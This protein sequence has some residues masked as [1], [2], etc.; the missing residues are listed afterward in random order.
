MGNWGEKTQLI[1]VITPL[2]TSRW[3]PWRYYTSTWLNKWSKSTSSSPYDNGFPSCLFVF[4][5][6][7]NMGS[8][9]GVPGKGHGAS[10]I[11]TG[12]GLEKNG[13]SGAARIQ[14]NDGMN[15]WPKS[16]ENKN[17]W[18]GSKGYNLLIHAISLGV[19]PTDPRPRFE[20]PWFLQWATTRVTTPLRG[21]FF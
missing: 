11:V 18:L 6:A 21:I 7:S 13:L 16:S 8:T 9:F 12:L 5:P 17:H 3:P 19:W 20:S 1:G 2:T 10:R 14:G 4:T 15:G